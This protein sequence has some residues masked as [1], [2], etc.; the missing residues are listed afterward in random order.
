I[1]H[2]APLIRGENL[3]G[4][5][6]QIENAVVHHDDGFDERPLHMKARLSDDPDRLAES[7]HQSLLGLINSEQRAPRP[8]QHNDGGGHERA[9]YIGFHRLPPVVDWGVWAGGRLRSSGSGRY[10]TTPP[11]PCP[12][13]S[14]MILSVPPNRRSMV[15]R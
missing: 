1:D 8:T 4:R 10:G 14:N 9:D 13:E 3:L 6:F 11:A 2:E 7:N 15:S 5:V 12:A